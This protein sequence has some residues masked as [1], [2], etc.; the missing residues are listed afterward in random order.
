VLPLALGVVGGT[1]R[2]QRAA[3]MALQLS[4]V[5]SAS[6]LAL[7]A[8]SVGL[9]SNL[10]ALR[11]LATLGIQLGHMS[12]HAR[13]VATAAGAVDDEVELVARTLS[14]RRDVT[15]RAAQTMLDELRAQRSAVAQM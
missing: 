14:E 1:L 7:L 10:A 11:A 12:L 6:E 8:A 5:S 4:A 2:L 3:R 13:S 9:A 15:L